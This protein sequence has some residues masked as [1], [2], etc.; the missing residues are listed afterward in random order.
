[1]ILRPPR[2]TRTVTLFPY[3]TLF[4][5]ID[6]LILLRRVLGIGDGPVG[7]GGEPLRVRGDP[8]VVGRRL[9]GHVEG[10]LEVELT[11]PGDERVEVLEAAQARVDR[12]VPAVGGPVRPRGPGVLSTEEGRV[13]AGWGRT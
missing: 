6:V 1:M 12:V 3:T 2:S 5:S 7:A 10:D 9:Q 8:G 11:G 4:R 13:G